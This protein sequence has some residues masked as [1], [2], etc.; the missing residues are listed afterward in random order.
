MSSSPDLCSP[1]LATKSAP[2]GPRKRSLAPTHARIL[3]VTGTNVLSHQPVSCS[4]KLTTLCARLKTQNHL[5]PSTHRAPASGCTTHLQ[6]SLWSPRQGVTKEIIGWSSQ[7]HVQNKDRPELTRL[8][9]HAFQRYSHQGPLTGPISRTRKNSHVFKVEPPKCSEAKALC[10]A[11][12]DSTHSPPHLHNSSS[13]G[14][15]RPRPYC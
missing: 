8:S 6:A 1:S 11:I 10:S 12:L 2:S 15:P 3:H 13:R 5:E 14:R 7:R 4:L 9:G